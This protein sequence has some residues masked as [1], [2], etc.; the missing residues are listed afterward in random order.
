MFDDDVYDQLSI[1]FFH[2]M[3]NCIGGCCIAVDY[4]LV[5][6]EVQGFKVV[7][8]HLRIAAVMTY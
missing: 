8:I 3:S 1:R 6:D 4:K 5:F 7:K 2:F